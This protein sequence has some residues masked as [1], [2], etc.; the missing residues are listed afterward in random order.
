MDYGPYGRDYG[1]YRVCGWGYVH[2][3]MGVGH[4]GEREVTGVSKGGQGEEVEGDI[5]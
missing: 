1:P 4:E 2:D 3:G 5:L